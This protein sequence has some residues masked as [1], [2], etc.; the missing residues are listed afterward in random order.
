[1]DTSYYFNSHSIYSRY[2]FNHVTKFIFYFNNN[3]YTFDHKVH[4]INR[5]WES[6]IY[7]TVETGAIYD[8]IRYFTEKIKRDVIATTGNN[9]RFKVSKNL[10]AE[11]T[12]N[13]PEILALK[14]ILKK[15]QY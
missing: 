13:S 2:G 4:Y 7:Q 9:L 10:F 5:T 6:R 8:A 14:K 1:M 3:R 12:K 15:N 11:K